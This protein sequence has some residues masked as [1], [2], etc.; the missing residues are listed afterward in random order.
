M[1]GSPAKSHGYNI[2][3]H[4]KIGGEQPK[5]IPVDLL[6]C[7]DR[8]RALEDPGR[9]EHQVFLALSSNQLLQE[10]DAELGPFCA[11]ECACGPGLASSRARLRKRRCP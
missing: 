5:N 1:H 8:V 3:A 10:S 4:E 6:D 2:I 11:P 9:Y 7:Q